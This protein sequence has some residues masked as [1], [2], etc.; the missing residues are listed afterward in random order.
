MVVKILT[1]GSQL[2]Y[3]SRYTG[4]YNIVLL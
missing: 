3:N 4:I 1:R 2:Y